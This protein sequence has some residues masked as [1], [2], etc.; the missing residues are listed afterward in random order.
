M[1]GAV[2]GAAELFRVTEEGYIYSPLIN[3]F[4]SCSAGQM[5][6][7]TSFSS[8][9]YNAPSRFISQIVE[10]ED[11][12]RSYMLVD[13]SQQINHIQSQT[14]T[15]LPSKAS[16]SQ[17]L[18]HSKSTIIALTVPMTSKG[19]NMKDVVDSPFWSNL[20]DSFMKSIDWRSNKISFR[21]YLGFDRADQLYDT[22][23]NTRNAVVG[24][25]GMDL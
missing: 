10:V 25:G 12:Q 9:S 13:L 2:V 6:S 1:G 3:G 8:Y 19:T 22:G 21:F 14:S 7:G 5:V 18:D 20:F 4:L 15:L 17:S 23:K 24:D 11:I 16:L